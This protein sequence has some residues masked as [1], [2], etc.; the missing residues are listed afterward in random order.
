MYDGRRT[1]MQKTQTFEYLTTPRL[2]NFRIHF[3]ESSKITEIEKHA[4][5]IVKLTMRIEDT[6]IFFFELPHSNAKENLTQ[7]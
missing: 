5:V 7:R 2:D 3:L 6:N 4:T 1:G